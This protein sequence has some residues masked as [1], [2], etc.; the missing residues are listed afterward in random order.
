MARAP[1]A[2]GHLLLNTQPWS[3]VYLDGVAVGNTPKTDLA[4]SPGSHR[5]R[6]VRDG[7]HPF[8]TTVVVAAG[9]SVR[10]TDIVLSSATP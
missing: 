10:L 3:E 8:E 6:F 2:D 1:G 5:L 4:V 7:F 9:A